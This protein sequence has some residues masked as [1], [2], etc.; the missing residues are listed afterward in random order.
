MS[1]EIGGLRTDMSKESG[2]I[3]TDMSK[4]IGTLR[5]EMKEGFADLRSRE[6]SLIRWMVGTGIGGMSAAVAIAKLIG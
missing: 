6:S 2:G 3:R 5:A 1:R 4:E